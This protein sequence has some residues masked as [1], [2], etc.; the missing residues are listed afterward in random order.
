ML[1]RRIIDSLMTVLLILLMSLQVTEQAAHE[2][3]G[4]VM[5]AVV[6]LH[7]YLNR[8]WFPALTRG[9]W[10]PLRVMSVSVNVLLIVSFTLSAVSGMMI[11]ETFTFMN[12]EDLTAWARE[13][14]IASSYWSFV[15]M[16]LHAG[17]HWGIIAGRI[18]TS[19]PGVLGVMFSGYGLYRFVV[20]RISDYL[21]LNSQFAFIDYDKNFMLVI[22]ENIAMLAFCVLLG[23]QGSRLAARPRDFKRPVISM[24]GMCLVC[25]VLI[26]IFGGPEEF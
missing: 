11:A 23:Y 20:S 18:R 4:V 3:L 25:A 21:T 9:R 17:M 22:I 14:H 5:F 15:L 26:V 1:A 8:K 7:Q 13:T 24:M 10:S 2:V 6:I 16:G 12:I 19:W